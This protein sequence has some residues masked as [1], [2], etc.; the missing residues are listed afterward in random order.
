MQTEPLI[1]KLFAIERAIGRVQPAQLRAMVIEAEEAALRMEL[2]N[3][4]SIEELQLRLRER[5]DEAR[6]GWA[7]SRVLRRTA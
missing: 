5:S 4:R 6:L 7:S 3:Y 1:Q 2:D